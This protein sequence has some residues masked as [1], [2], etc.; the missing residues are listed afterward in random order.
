MEDFYYILE[1]TK[2][3]RVNLEKDEEFLLNIP[4]LFKKVCRLCLTEV[5]VL[6]PIDKTYK[7]I[8]YSM[9]VCKILNIVISS[10]QDQD[11]HNMICEE[12]SS[13]LILFYKFREKI[14]NNNDTLTKL[15]S[16][17]YQ[18]KYP[19]KVEDEKKV[20]ES[21]QDDDDIQESIRAASVTKLPSV[22]Y[23]ASMVESFTVSPNQNLCKKIR[24][25]FFLYLLSG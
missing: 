12:C 18:I 4:E 20:V 16:F 14:E 13:N 21:I 8:T 17:I 1:K 23:A 11:F 7:N 19:M 5:E 9:L 15:K 22:K 24:L 3:A 25:Q 2:N 10:E 6:Q